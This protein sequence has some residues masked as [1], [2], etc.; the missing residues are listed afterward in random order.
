MGLISRWM[1]KVTRGDYIDL[2]YFE[3]RDTEGSH[4]EQPRNLGYLPS[5]TQPEVRAA[6]AHCGLTSK[7]I[8]SQ[9]QSN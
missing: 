1:G 7:H 3:T 6:L 5:M 4:M 9:V 2:G 8:E